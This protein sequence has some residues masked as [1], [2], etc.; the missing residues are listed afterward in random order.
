MCQTKSI[1]VSLSLILLV[2]ANFILY[3]VHLEK[4]LGHQSGI[5]SKAPHENH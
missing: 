1:I 2:T 5:K 4:K 3:Q